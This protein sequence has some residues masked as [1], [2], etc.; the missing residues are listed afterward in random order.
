MAYEESSGDKK[1]RLQTELGVKHQRLA[2]KYAEASRPEQAVEAFEKA[3]EYLPDSAAIYHN[4][5]VL[6]AQYRE[7]E[8]ARTLLQRALA[9]EPGSKPTQEALRMVEESLSQRP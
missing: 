8:R 3:L 4:Y 7:F 9:I 6:L 5:A 2:Q 1:L